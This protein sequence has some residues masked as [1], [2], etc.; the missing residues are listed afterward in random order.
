MEVLTI[1]LPIGLFEV[2]M[3]VTRLSLEGPLV[4]RLPGVGVS[5]FAIGILWVLVAPG[6]KKKGE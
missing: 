6:Q 2:T 4:Y 1:F 5:V 3:A